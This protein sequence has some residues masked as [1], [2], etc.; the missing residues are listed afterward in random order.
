MQK[1]NLITKFFERLKYTI[2]YIY[3]RSQ[4]N[5]SCKDICK[6]SCIEN[7][8]ITSLDGLDHNFINIG[9]TPKQKY[10]LSRLYS[11][12]KLYHKDSYEV[13]IGPG[14]YGEEIYNVTCIH[15]NI[16]KNLIIEL[17]KMTFD[18]Q[19]YKLLELE[20]K[21]I[22]D[23]IKNLHFVIKNA[24]L[25]ALPATVA[26]Y[27]GFTHSP[28][29]CIVHDIGNKLSIIDGHHRLNYYLSIGQ[30]KGKIIFGKKGSI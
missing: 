19:I 20:Y 22:P 6:C 9:K 28:Y 25:A 26:K 5:G 13:E 4:C 2:E 3:D 27:G 24:R 10:I 15:E 7:V 8:K 11:I 18:Q 1:I 29:I 30:T 23:N 16:I 17:N 14:Y 21:Y 12:Y